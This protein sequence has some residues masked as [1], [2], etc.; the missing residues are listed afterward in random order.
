MALLRVYGDLFCGAGGFT[1]GLERALEKLGISDALDIFAINHWHLAVASHAQ[2]H[3]KVRH[4][5]ADI[6]SVDP[7]LV[8][9]GRVMELLLAAPECT[10]HSRARGGRPIN[11]QKRA[12]PRRIIDWAEKLYIKRILVENVPEVVRWGPVEL[13]PNSKR[14][15]RPIK[16]R[17]GEFF[18]RW[19]KDLELLDYN[20][21]WRILNAANYGA[22]TTRERFFLQ[23]KKRGRGI[24][25][26]ISW[27]EPTHKR[28]GSNDDQP[29]LFGDTRKPWRAAREIIDRSIPSK[30]IFG[31]KKPLKDTTLKR[32]ATGFAKR[33]ASGDPFVIA[34]R[35]LA[36]SVGYTLDETWPAPAF[37]RNTANAGDSI[38][39]TLRNHED[40]RSVNL[41]IPTVAPNG[42]HISL[43]E[44]QAMVLGQH[45]GAVCR[46]ESEPLP[47]VAGKGAIAHIQPLIFANQRQANQATDASKPLQITTATSSDFALVEP[48]ITT[49]NHGT[50]SK[51][52]HARRARSLDEPIGTIPGSNTFGLV[53]PQVHFLTTDGGPEGQGRN[54]T[55]MH[56]PNDRHV[57]VDGMIV[58]FFGER[59]GQK[60]RSHSL[61]EPLPA[62]TTHGA[63]GLVDGFLTHTN[64]G[65]DA[66]TGELTN[67]LPTITSV[68]AMGLTPAEFLAIYY[69]TANSQEL[70][71]PFHTVTSKD[72]FAFV[73]GTISKDSDGKANGYLYRDRDETTYLIDIHFRMLH[74]KELSLGQSFPENYVYIGNREAVVKQI[75]NAVPPVLAEQLI[76]AVLDMPAKRVLAGDERVA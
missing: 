32:I 57:L 47:T 68:D 67:L 8:V 42:N 72:R 25:A 19:I 65:K 69:G 23:A 52:G 59:K 73:A 76:L 40:S 11:D 20:V 41:R 4:I 35:E 9:P 33:G 10:H 7:W 36:K 24:T 48:F 12:G 26:A 75:G 16:S 71:D 37:E 53:E 70:S 61:N 6:E 18:C 49:A 28:P 13:N 43:C 51:D 15:G 56:Q 45:G 17:E 55:E 46:D 3:P 22:P 27:P 21:E 66:R 14:F 38:A 54:A 39:V 5:C 60:P 58:P 30:S 2:N 62:I 29:L 1:E 50:D 63:G 64:H 44:I 34:V 31:R 74:P